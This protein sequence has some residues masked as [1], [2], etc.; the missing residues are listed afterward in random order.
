[1]ITTVV[2][3]MKKS[4][5]LGKLELEVLRFVA[6]SR[7]ISVGDAAAK[8]GE[9]R[10]YARTTIQTVMERLRS[11]NCLDRQF[12]EGVYLYSI[13]A[14]GTRVLESLVKEFVSETLGGH[15]T[16]IVAF[17]ADAENLTPDEI[18]ALRRIVEQADER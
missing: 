8:F 1:M 9:P 3:A 11:K 2:T 7:P 16:P 14:E 18:A 6:D 4:Q 15:L 10:G 13:T 5:S 17:L 12:E